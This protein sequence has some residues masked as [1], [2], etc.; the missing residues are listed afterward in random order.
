MDWFEKYAFTF[1]LFLFVLVLFC[2][3]LKKLSLDLFFWIVLY[4]SPLISS[5]LNSFL[6]VS[7]SSSIFYFCSRIRRSKFFL[8]SF[9]L[10]FNRAIWSHV[11]SFWVI[12]VQLVPT[13]FI[14]LDM[15]MFL[16][17]SFCFSPGVVI[18][19]CL[20]LVSYLFSFIWFISFHF[21]FFCIHLRSSTFICFHT[22]KSFWNS[23]HPLI[24][25]AF[26][27]NAN[28]EFSNYLLWYDLIA[29]Y[30]SRLVIFLCSCFWW[31]WNIC[32]VLR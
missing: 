16:L 31:F 7:I 26:L 5:M 20:T 3:F 4:I 22:Y 18:Y 14:F 13:K 28:F 23:I 8:I 19:V 1:V 21:I 9:W 15:Y 11:F 17:F 10:L 30:S 2:Y 25:Q 24:L 6:I 32:F 27:E 12:C 29:F